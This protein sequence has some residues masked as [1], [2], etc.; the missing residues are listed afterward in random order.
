[1]TTV[2]FNLS[3]DR[4]QYTPE[5]AVRGYLTTGEIQELWHD[6]DCGPDGP[7]SYPPDARIPVKVSVL[8]RL[9]GEVYDRRAARDERAKAELEDN[10]RAAGP[11]LYDALE[12][13]MDG[14]HCACPA[15]RPD[16]P[17]C[18]GREALRNARL[19]VTS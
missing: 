3:G 2:R 18:V 12:L 15:F 9:A 1:M 11:A 16:C 8:E 13:L 14:R 7:G 10:K 19:G 5:D 17:E 6:A 4:P